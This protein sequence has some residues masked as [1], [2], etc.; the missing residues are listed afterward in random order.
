M[1]DHLV[2]VAGRPLVEPAGQRALGHHPQRIGPPLR[3][4]RGHLVG[5]LPGRSLRAH[6]RP[7]RRI[8]RRRGAVASGAA[9]SG[10]VA[11]GAVASGA[12]A[13]S[14]AASGAVASG[15]AA[16][17]SPPAAA[18]DSRRRPRRLRPRIERRLQRPPQHG[19]HLRRQ[20]AADHD[21]PVVVH[22]GVEGA[23]LVPPPVLRLL[24]RAVDPP[25]RADHL[26]DVRGGA[27]EGDVEQRLLGRGGRHAGDGAH[28]RVGDGAAPQRLAQ[29]RQLRQGVGDAHLLAGGARREADAPAQPVGAG[30]EAFPAV[31]LVELADEDE[32]LV[33]GGLDAGGEVGYPVAERLDVGRGLVGAR[34]LHGRDVG[35]GSRSGRRSRRDGRNGNDAG[36]DRHDSIITPSFSMACTA[37]GG[38]IGPQYGFVVFPGAGRPP[39]AGQGRPS[40]MPDASRHPRPPASKRAVNRKMH[41]GRKKIASRPHGVG[42]GQAHGG[43]HGARRRELRASGQLLA[44]LNSSG[45]WRGRLGAG[46]SVDGFGRS[47]D[48]RRAQPTPALRDEM[49]AARAGMRPKRRATSRATLG[50]MDLGSC[51]LDGARRRLGDSRRGE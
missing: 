51:L 44:S 39:A 49:A 1:D 13:S 19:A 37:S 8:G 43:T 40:G 18:S 25:P 21:H 36:L 6:R 27:G 16:R 35:L 20:P 7:G 11:S 42:D 23:R 9:A 41:A 31:A 32:Q 38:P 2:A 14:T 34:G 12:V 26:L 33:G 17:G 28:L 15:P 10:A 47:V 3:D 48:S 50:S 46:P 29:P 22:P 45:R 5:G 30:G 24:G 4:G